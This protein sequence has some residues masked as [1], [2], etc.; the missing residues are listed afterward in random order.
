MSFMLIGSTLC[1]A[2]QTWGMLLFGRALQGVSAAG[3][4]NMIKIVLS[5]KVSLA[6]QSKNNTIF[7]LCYGIFFSVGPVIGGALADSNW[8]YCFVLSIPI[9]ALCHA[10]LFFVLRKELVQGTHQIS[11]PNRKSILSGLSTIDVGGMILF[12]LG[13]GLLILGVTWGGTKYPWTGYQ[14]L[15]PM[16]LGAVLFVSFFVYEYLLEPGRLISRVFP[17]QVPMVPWSL[18]QKKDVALLCLINCATGAALYSAF[19]F[20]S[21]FWTIAEGMSPTDAG[22]R[23]LYYT[24]GLGSK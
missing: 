22:L 13:A 14:V 17:K 11:G 15:L 12:V 6:E 1:A 19:Y 8:R 10:L 16:I 7:T 4:M 20:I 3:I 23:L 2:A 9:A 21:I 18:L 24:P 5:D